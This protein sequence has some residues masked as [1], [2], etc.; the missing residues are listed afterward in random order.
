[1]SVPA[2]LVQKSTK[3]IVKEALYPRADLT[4]FPIGDIDP[5]Y[6]WLIKH[7]PHE[8][9][10]YDSRIF[11][12]KMILPEMEELNLFP[13][14]PLYTGIRAYVI[15]Y[16][17]E[18]RPKAEI[19]IEIENAEKEANNKVFSDIIHKEELLLI[20]NSIAKKSEGYVLSP[21]EEERIANLNVMAVKQLKNKDNKIIKLEQLNS[22]NTPNISEG[23]EN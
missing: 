22:G 6:E 1:M 13:Q 16:G 20:S 12:G 11:I 5:D 4:P 2:V 9:V 15:N 18:Q 10:P 17:V 23:W 7:T 8:Q 3:I 14:H 19:I 21:E